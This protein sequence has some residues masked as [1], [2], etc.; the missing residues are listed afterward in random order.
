MDDATGRRLA[1]LKA[2]CGCTA[3]SAA[4]LLSVAAYV[5]YA[6]WLD[7]VSRSLGERLITGIVVGLVAMLLGKILGVLWARYQ[8]HHLLRLLESRQL[9][10][11]E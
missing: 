6:V 7:P 3:G 1:K 8:Y 5:I 9:A 10:A 2:E 4:L 11:G